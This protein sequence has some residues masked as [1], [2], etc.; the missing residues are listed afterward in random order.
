ML[1][2]PLRRGFLVCVG[3]NRSPPQHSKR[4]TSDRGWLYCGAGLCPT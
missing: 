3:V 2:T 4:D 1:P